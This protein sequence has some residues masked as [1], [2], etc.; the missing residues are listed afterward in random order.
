MTHIPPVIPFVDHE[1]FPKVVDAEKVTLG[2]PQ[3]D[4]ESGEL[5]RDKVVILRRPRHPALFHTHSLTTRNTI[6]SSFMLMKEQKK[7]G[8]FRI[9]DFTRGPAKFK[10]RQG[11]M[12]YQRKPVGPT[13]QTRVCMERGVPVSYTTTRTPHT[14]LISPEEVP[15][16]RR[17]FRVPC[18]SLPSDQSEKPLRNPKVI[19]VSIWEEFLYGTSVLDV[20]TGHGGEEPDGPIGVLRAHLKR[21][22]SATVIDMLVLSV[23]FTLYFLSCLAYNDFWELGLY[24]LLAN[25]LQIHE[26]AY[27]RKMR[28]DFTGS[29]FQGPAYVCVRTW[30]QHCIEKDREKVMF[31]LMKKMKADIRG[32]SEC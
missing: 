1:G 12:R 14:D 10:L 2:Y 3:K 6:P 4:S 11:S 7:F 15:G 29:A 26:K 22:L 13:F 18:E 9:Q 24:M 31:G 8:G 27:K 5:V 23:Y 21:Y 30:C 20:M 32:T 17:I 19:C 25:H 28:I 16:V